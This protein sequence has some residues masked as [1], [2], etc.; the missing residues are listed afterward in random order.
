MISIIYPYR[1]R[2]VLRVK[3]SLKSLQLQTNKNF[4]VYF[5]NYGS[6]KNH[7]Q[8][9]EKL[10]E[11][12]SF[13]NYSYLYTEFQP[14]NKSK[15][16]NNVL[17][18]LEKDYF[19]VADIDMIFHPNFIEKTLELAK[20]ND[21]WYF[22]VG[23]LSEEESNSDKKFEDYKI[24]FKSN[25]GATGLTM[26][27]VKS[28]KAIQGFDEFYHFWG[29]E[30]T[31][32]HVRLKNSGCNVKYYSQDIMMLH[33]WHKIYRNEESE[34]LT[35]TLQIS[36]IVQFNHYYLKQTILNK[37]AIVNN[38]SWGKTQSKKEYEQ[39]VDFSKNNS[40]TLSNYTSEID[41]F[42]F[43]KLPNLERGLH[44]FE[45]REKENA[46]GLKTTLKSVFKLNKEKSYSLKTIN[47]KLLFYIINFY[48]NYPYNY[49]VSEDL[50]S[51]K[52][53]INKL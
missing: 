19:F 47:N 53:V 20:T 27:S 23:F 38:K 9:I 13:V 52:F 26:C 33:Q 11:K 3:N 5:V 25:E 12:F 15:A 8:Q 31:D 46:E 4:E 16:I 10:L 44:S 34:S 49:C 14:W 17:K 42:L 18:N 32:F 41:Y 51:I 36:G 35:K 22:Q 43:Q 37:K 2:D 6:S 1:N 29:S 45:I 28:A 48:R 40:N 7:T 50:K 39:L 30:D 24:K 21:T